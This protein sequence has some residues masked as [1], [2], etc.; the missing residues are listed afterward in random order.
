MKESKKL[1]EEYSLNEEEQFL[2]PYERE[3]VKSLTAKENKNV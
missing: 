2:S 3:Y 1:L